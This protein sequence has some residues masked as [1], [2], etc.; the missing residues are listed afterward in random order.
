MPERCFVACLQP[1]SRFAAQTISQRITAVCAPPHFPFAGGK[2]PKGACTLEDGYLSQYEIERYALPN[3]VKVDTTDHF[4][5]TV[6][7]TGTGT[8]FVGYDTMGAQAH[9]RPLSRPCVPTW[10]RLRKRRLRAHGK[11]VMRLTG[12]R[13]Y[14]MH[15]AV[16]WQR[17]NLMS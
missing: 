4:A 8:G 3:T 6:Y 13:R 2:G 14:P 15:Y 12:R 11:H 17:S 10:V 5:T 16:H 9:E 1:T 7:N